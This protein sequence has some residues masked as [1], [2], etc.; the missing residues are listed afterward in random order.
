MCEETGKYPGELKGKKA[1]RK[2]DA[3]RSALKAHFFQIKR[4]IERRLEIN[5]RILDNVTSPSGTTIAGIR[6]LEKAGFRSAAIEA[7][8]AATERCK[9]LS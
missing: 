5:S 1:I 8:I 7:V 3:I 6:A 9:E 2:M 4:S